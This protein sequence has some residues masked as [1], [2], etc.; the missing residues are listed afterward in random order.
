M[1]HTQVQFI[2]RPALRRVLGTKFT[3]V[4]IFRRWIDLVNKSRCTSIKS[5]RARVRWQAPAYRQFRMPFG[6]YGRF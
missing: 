2:A 6:N 5:T 3:I 1:S 4:A